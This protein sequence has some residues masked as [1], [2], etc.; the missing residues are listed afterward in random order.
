MQF[1][2]ANGRLA[3][4]SPLW[5]CLRAKYDVHLRLIG[6]RVVDFLSVL[7]K[8]FFDKC[9]GW[10]ATSKYRLKIG[11]FALDVMATTCHLQEKCEIVK[12][13]DCHLVIQQTACTKATYLNRR[14]KS[15]CSASFAR[16]MYRCLYVWTLSQN[17]LSVIWR[18]LWRSSTTAFH[19]AFASNKTPS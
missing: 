14:L 12:G 3:F 2:T 16:W 1:Q 11:V 13:S 8:L 15:V 6:E 4:L 19:D 18:C 17:W 10:G 9:Y 7:I 5:G